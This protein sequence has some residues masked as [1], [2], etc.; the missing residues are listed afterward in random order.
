MMSSDYLGYSIFPWFMVG[1]HIYLKNYS[2]WSFHKLCCIAF[3][4]FLLGFT[5][6]IKNSWFVYSAALCVFIKLSYIF[7]EHSAKR[8]LRP[9][10]VSTFSVISFILPVVT[11]E[12]YNL[13]ATGTSAL[14]YANTGENSD[15]EWYEQ[16]Y[17]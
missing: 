16:N 11:L 14:T 17:G 3:I 8:Y 9:L 6:W 13:N 4:L 1:G 12:L 2:N 5:Y 15:G 10:F 7:R